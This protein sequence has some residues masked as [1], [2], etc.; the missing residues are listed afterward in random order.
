MVRGGRQEGLNVLATGRRQ[1]DSHTATLLPQYKYFCLEPF[2]LS[3][4]LEVL[5]SRGKEFAPGQE[6]EL[7]SISLLLDLGKSKCWG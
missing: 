1:E 2:A 5:Q 6:H 3:L 4:L 7:R